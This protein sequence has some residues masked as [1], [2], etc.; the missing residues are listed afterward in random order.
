MTTQNAEL[1]HMHHFEDK[2]H[3]GPS[4]WLLWDCEAPSLLHP[5]KLKFILL[6]LQVAQVTGF[7]T[8]S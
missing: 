6:K 8:C 7:L 3:P 1:D 5:F 2:V 4:Q